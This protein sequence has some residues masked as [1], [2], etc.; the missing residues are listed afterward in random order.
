MDGIDFLHRTKKTMLDALANSCLFFLSFF[1]FHSLHNDLSI[2]PFWLNQ[3]LSS[4]SSR[5]LINL[6]VQFF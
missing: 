1:F 2:L 3:V 5:T 6:F 4:P